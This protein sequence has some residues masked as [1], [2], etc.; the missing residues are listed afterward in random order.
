MKNQRTDETSEKLL[1]AAAK[2]FSAKGYSGTRLEDIALES[3]YTRGAISFLFKNKHN[4]FHQLAQNY[5]NDVSDHITRLM[6]S[7]LP[8]HE[9]LENLLDY[10]LDIDANYSKL[11]VI[12]IALSGEPKELSDLPA[13]FKE[14]HLETLDLISEII[15]HR[16]LCESSDTCVDPEFAAKAIFTFCRGLYGDIGHFSGNMS[17]EAIK[18]NSKE[19]FLSYLT[20]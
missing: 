14:N 7:S 15:T 16:S 8:P 20:C 17:N 13:I 11:A 5:F 19:L 10:A 12:N 1:Q 18:K 3:G 2:V 6:S 9:K 4:L